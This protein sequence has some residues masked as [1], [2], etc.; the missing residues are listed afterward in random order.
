MKKDQDQPA[1]AAE[2]RRRAEQRLSEKRKSQRS[3]AGDQ[4]TSEDAARLVHELQ[5]HQIELEMQN[6]ELRASQAEVEAGLALYAELYDSA[7]TGYLTLDR[8]GAIRLVN[9]TGAHLLGV[10]RSRL[11]KRRF[12]QFVAESDRRAFSD[13]LEKAFASQAKEC[14][15]VTLPREGL[16]PLVVQIEGTRSA[17]GQECRAVTLDITER[18]RAEEA[19]RESERGLKEAQRLGRIGHWQFDVKAQRLRWSDMVFAIYERDPKRGPPTVEEEAAYYSSQDAERLRDCA[20]RVIE[21][22]EPYEIEMRVNLPEGRIADVVAIGT[23]VKDAHGRVISLMG[24]VQDITARK[25]VE[26]ALAESELKYRQVVENATEAIFVAR[27]K[28]ILFANPATSAM[29]GYST[30]EIL[31]RPFV[32]FI[33]PDDLDMVLER[34]Y[35]RVKGEESPTLSVIRVVRKDGQ[36]RWVELSTVLIDW[37]GEPAT[38]NLASDIT[39]SRE[40]SDRL[41]KSLEGT[42]KAVALTTEMRDPYTAGHQERVTRLACAMARKMGLSEETVEGLRVAGLLHDVGKASV[43]AEILSK[44]SPLTPAEFDLVKTH[45]QTGYDI[46]E[47]IRFPWPVAEIVREHHE[48][49]DGSGYPRGLKGEAISQEAKILAVADVVE[50]MAS[51]RPYRPALGVDKALEDVEREA[52]V[53]YDPEVV[54]ACLALFQE[55]YA[56]SRTLP[57]AR[58]G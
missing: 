36:V 42:I 34:Y 9:L 20:R 11:V 54:K 28:S 45:S 51:H 23:P 47:R 48:R 49:L 53:L 6:E 39:E 13:F 3:E 22:S 46:L 2:L 58:Q 29:I 33:H 41:R 31:A 21:A 8:K 30:E 50:A 17:D 40:A 14:C 18:K 52:G 56:L 57:E 37:Q 55:G 16:Q 32:D 24:T 10:E 19:L 43:P 25:Q 44:P 15:E 38:L 4:R 27:H 5:V 26:A 12:G 7:P 1:E 35:A